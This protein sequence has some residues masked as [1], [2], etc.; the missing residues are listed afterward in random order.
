MLTVKIV[1]QVLHLVCA[2]F[3]F[4]SLMWTEVI[5]WPRMRG[6]NMIVP[7]QGVL[8]AVAV[9]K[10]QAFPIF[11]TVIL[12]F[13][14]GWVDG[15]FDRLNTPYGIMFVLAAIFGTTMVVW[16]GSF[17]TRDRVWSWRSFYTGFWVLFALMIGLR[18]TV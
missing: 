5:L 4:G 18:F 10:I 7:V 1:L 8:R 2:I 11:G 6:A 17:P 9:R 3:W 13:A 15:V 14:R 12:G 16:W